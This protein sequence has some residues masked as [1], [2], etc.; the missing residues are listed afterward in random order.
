MCFPIFNPRVPYLLLILLPL[1]LQC[2]RSPLTFLMLLSL[3]SVRS[4][5]AYVIGAVRIFRCKPGTSAADGGKDEAIQVCGADGEWGGDDLK[6]VV[7][8]TAT[9]S[10]AT[11]TTGKAT[12]YKFT[13]TGK[14]EFFTVPEN[15]DGYKVEVRFCFC[16]FYVTTL[17]PH[18]LQFTE[19]RVSVSPD[20]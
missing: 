19:T 6:C 8:T 3:H 7:T 17:T 14:P 11:T 10:T 5:H 13:Y 12:M 9:T 1:K 16:F 15:G 20:T 18:P 2:N 4:V